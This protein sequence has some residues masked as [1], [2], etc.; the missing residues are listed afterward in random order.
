MIV[1]YY[2]YWGHVEVNGGRKGEVRDF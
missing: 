1:H 2:C